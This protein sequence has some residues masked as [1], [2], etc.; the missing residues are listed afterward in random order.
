MQILLRIENYLTIESLFHLTAI[1]ENTVEEA[2]LAVNM[3][4]YIEKEISSYGNYAI[5]STH[6]NSTDSGMVWPTGL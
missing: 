3:L 4:L 2:F 1:E 6:A 5:R